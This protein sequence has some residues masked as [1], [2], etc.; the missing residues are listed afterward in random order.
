METIQFRST[1]HHKNEMICLAAIL[2]LDP[3]P[4]LDI[5][6]EDHDRGMVELL[7]MVEPLLLVVLFQPPPL[8]SQR[9]FCWA[10]TSFLNGSRNISSEPLGL[11]TVKQG[12]GQVENY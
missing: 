8:L 6:D 4:L 7:Q 12:S 5:P 2:G 10:P 3:A 11:S 1:S 9:G